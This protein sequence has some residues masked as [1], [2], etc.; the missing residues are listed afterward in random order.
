MC[1]YVCVCECLLMGDRISYIWPQTPYVAETGL[2]PQLL[3][4]PISLGLG[5]WACTT[6]LGFEL[7]ISHSP[8][9]PGEMVAVPSH[10]ACPV[11]LLPDCKAFYENPRESHFSPASILNSLFSFKFLTLPCPTVEIISCALCK[12]ILLSK[13]C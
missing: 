8:L 1:V 11:F 3:L 9:S 4:P 2:E 6:T 13:K 7:L 12:S 10:S 5:F